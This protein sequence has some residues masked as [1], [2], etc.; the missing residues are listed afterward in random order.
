MASSSSFMTTLPRGLAMRVYL[1]SLALQASWNDERMQNLGLLATLAPWLRRQNLD[2]T[3]RRRFCQRHIGVFN[4]NPYLAN[5]IIGGILRLESEALREGPAPTTTSIAAYRD[6]LARVC[7]SLGDQ[8]F[9]LGLRPGIAMATILLGFFGQ[10]RWLL[11]L[12]ACFAMGQLLAR[13]RW[14]ADGYAMGLD[15]VDLLGRPAWNRAIRWTKRG[16][17]ALTG[18]VAGIYVAGVLDLNDPG[19]SREW[20]VVGAVTG[21]LLPLVLRQRLPGEAQALVGLLLISGAVW[22]F[23]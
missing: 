18:V 13:G 11:V 15:I 23:G 16:A 10:W 17:L 9:W 6:T 19:S 4:T 8:L 7:G 20:T 5:I 22:L 2:V 3:R 12:V 21:V 14:L 1:R